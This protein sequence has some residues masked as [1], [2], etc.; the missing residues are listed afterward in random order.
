MKNRFE[1]KIK[2]GRPTLLYHKGVRKNVQAVE[3]EKPRKK[4]RKKNV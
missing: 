2:N 3:E 4:G 1:I